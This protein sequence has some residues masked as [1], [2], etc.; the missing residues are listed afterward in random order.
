MGL[1]KFEHT[2]IEVEG[3]NCRVIENGIT[4]ERAEFLRTLLE[5]NKIEVKVT[6]ETPKKEGDPITWAISTPDVTFNPVVKVYNRELRSLDGH[7]VTPDFWNQAADTFE[8]NYWDW[9]K[10]KSGAGS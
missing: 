3:V 7:R 10:K 5:H 2:I 6:Q 9:G 8:P 4:K 1:S